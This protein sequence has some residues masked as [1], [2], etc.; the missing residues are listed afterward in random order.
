[1]V[2]FNAMTAA[3]AQVT[4]PVM[5]AAEEYAWATGADNVCVN[6]D[7]A[8]SNLEQEGQLT[9]AQRDL[10]RLCRRAEDVVGG[11]LVL[12]KL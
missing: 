8:I 12:S 6:C 3:Y 1:M 5:E 2:K 7:T 9:E 4:A 11:D 10:L